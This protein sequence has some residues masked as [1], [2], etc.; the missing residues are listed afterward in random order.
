M[1]DLDPTPIM[2]SPEPHWCEDCQEDHW[3]DLAER[4]RLRAA[5]AEAQEREQKIRALTFASD[6]GSEYE[7][8]HG[9]A[10]GYPECPACWAADIHR[11]L[12]GD[13]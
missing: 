8:E 4:D 1:T 13:A 11:A 10:D 9:P 12:D 5:L 6:D 7:H 2:T 3:L